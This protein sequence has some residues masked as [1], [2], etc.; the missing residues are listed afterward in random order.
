[1]FFGKKNAGLIVKRF[2]QAAGQY[3]SGIKNNTYKLEKVLCL[4]YITKNEDVCL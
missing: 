3:G 2:R 4:R 1:M